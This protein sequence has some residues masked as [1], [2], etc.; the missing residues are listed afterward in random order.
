MIVPAPRCRASFTCIM[1]MMPSPM[2]RI[3]SPGLSPER[4]SDFTTHAAGSTRTP[5]ASLI[6]SGSLNVSR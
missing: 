1:P 2:I 6:E 5:S 4:L 3:D